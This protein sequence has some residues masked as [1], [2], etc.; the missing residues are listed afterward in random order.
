MKIS[1]K[2][3]LPIRLAIPSRSGFKDEWNIQGSAIFRR[4]FDSLFLRYGE[5]QRYLLPSYDKLLSFSLHKSNS[6]NP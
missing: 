5:E 3:K 1:L 4:V 6:K 2:H